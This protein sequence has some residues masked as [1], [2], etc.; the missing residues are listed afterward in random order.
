MAPQEPSYARRTNYRLQYWT[1]ASRFPGMMNDTHQSNSKARSR[2]RRFLP[3]HWSQ[4]LLILSVHLPNPPLPQRYLS[5]RPHWSHRSWGS[6]QLC[7]LP[8]L[9]SPRV[10]RLIPDFLAS[11]LVT[12]CACL[13]VHWCTDSFIYHHLHT[14]P[15]IHSFDF[16]QMSFESLLWFR[17]TKTIVNKTSSSFGEVTVQMLMCL[18]F[19]NSPWGFLQCDPPGMFLGTLL[20]VV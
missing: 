18:C 14:H 4:A 15:T 2:P 19:P 6:S 10:T 9:K 8:W 16:E 17:S 11:E 1:L 3:S 12:S 13:P 7:Y 20:L 5:V